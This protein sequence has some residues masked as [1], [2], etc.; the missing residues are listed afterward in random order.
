MRR[1]SAQ[2]LL[3]LAFLGGANLAE[4][5]LAQT[6]NNRASCDRKYGPE[7][8]DACAALIK[9]GR[10]TAQYLAYDYNNRGEAYAYKQDY[11]HAEMDYTQA[12]R[13]LPD[14][15]DAFVNRARIYQG[16]KDFDRAIADL[17]EAIRLDGNKSRRFYLNRA[18]I[19]LAKGDRGRALADYNEVVKFSSERPGDQ[20]SS[21]LALI[22]LEYSANT[23]RDS[24][25]YDRA[26]GD[27]G[28]AISLDPKEGRLF[29]ERGILSVYHGSISNAAA[30]LNRA[31]ELFSAR[32]G[33]SYLYDVLWLDIVNSRMK[34]PSDL[35]ARLAAAK[36]HID[37][38]EW[39]A[40]IVRLH[41]GQWSMETMLA[42][43]AAVDWRQ[44][45]AF[46]YG[47]EFS[48]QNGAKE[49]AVRLLT[50]ASES[51]SRSAVVG[52]AANAELEAL[53]RIP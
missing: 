2:F 28:K 11:D 12:I 17:S 43:A 39:P 7:A 14:Y 25:E 29:F 19:Y 36:E 10:E 31:G 30:D 45:D 33:S 47:G 35:I 20:N 1:I 13:L 48:L 15:S 18:E 6:S 16:K 53:G 44:C 3:A 42:A 21:R 8:I 50:R 23:R 34:R 27:Y 4:I 37:V 5:A 24:G 52:F 32:G 51:C 38:R 22:A 40:P 46:F 26:L 41:L 9:S 49:D